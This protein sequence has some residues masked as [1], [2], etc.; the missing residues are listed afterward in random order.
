MEHPPL[1]QINR[2]KIYLKRQVNKTKA[3]IRMFSALKSLFNY[4]EN[5]NEE[6]YLYRNVIAEIEIHMD[7]EILNARAKRMKWR[8]SKDK[9]SDAEDIMEIMGEFLKQ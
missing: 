1:K 5:D 3:V 8:F 4:L 9:V 6:F 7:K 2:F